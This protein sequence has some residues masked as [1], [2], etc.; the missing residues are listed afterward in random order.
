MKKIFLWIFG[1]AVGYVLVGALIDRVIFPESNAPRDY[2]PRAGSTFVSRTEGFRQTIARHEN[3]LV[4]LELELE[5]H[6]AG[7]PE[8]I[9]GTIT[10]RFMVAEGTLSLM[11]NGEKKILRAGE[12]LEVPPGTPH[13]P[14]NETGARTIVKGPLTPENALPEEFIIFLTQAYGVF[15]E[16]PAETNKLNA[17]LQMSR[18]AP[19]YDLWLAGP[20]VFLQKTLFFIIGPTARLF[21]YRTFYEKYK[22]PA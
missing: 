9:H 8:H 5:P 7:P 6:A 19:K 22:P 2:Y 20:P 18:F 12:M 17:M 14:F 10:E 21:G 1:F 3:G 15:D 13:K 4:W 16:S 11:V